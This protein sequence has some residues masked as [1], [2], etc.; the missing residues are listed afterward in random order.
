MRFENRFGRGVS[1]LISALIS[2]VGVVIVSFAAS[3]SAD[4]KELRFANYFGSRMVL[5]REKPVP[6][7]G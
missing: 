7:W 2:A 6:V 5:Q 3:V 1:A 4:E